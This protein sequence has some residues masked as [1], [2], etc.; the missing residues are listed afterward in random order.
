MPDFT[1]RPYALW[2]VKAIH[3]PTEGEPFL[4]KKKKKKTTGCNLRENLQW[5]ESQE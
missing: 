5:F 4:I 1:T 2:N 3:G